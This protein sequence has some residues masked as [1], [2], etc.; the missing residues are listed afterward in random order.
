MHIE[1]GVIDAAKMGLSYA[2]AVA[3]VGLTVKSVY[4]NIKE[5]HIFSFIGK[6]ALTTLGVIIFFEILPHRP[7]G[8]SEVHFIFG[9]TLFLLF[10][11]APTALGLASGLLLQSLFLSPLDIPQYGANVT[12]LLLPLFAMGFMAK[13]FIPQNIAYKDIK[14]RDVLKL[15]CFYQAGIIGWVSFWAFYG[16]GFGA[17]N[18]MSVLTFSAAYLSVI[19]VEP[20]VDL[21]F[22]ALVK[23]MDS[24]KK[25]PILDPR[26][27]NSAP[28]IPSASSAPN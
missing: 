18:A 16:Q 17:E 24:L 1:A 25:S 11:L 14:Y 27:F 12:T 6:W 9:S 3:A 7:V 20:F 4:E 8:V 19:V 2:T 23:N 15:S 26:L 5:N 10:G 21:G 13:Q 22:L 28:S